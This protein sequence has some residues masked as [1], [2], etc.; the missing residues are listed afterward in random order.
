MQNRIIHK[1]AKG[2]NHSGAVVC[3]PGNKPVAEDPFLQF[4]RWFADAGKKGNK[5]PGAMHLSTCGKNGRPSG[6]MVLLKNVDSSG[7]VFF[8]N[9]ESRKGK[10]IAEN[11]FVA[12]TFFWPE[13]ERQV[14]IEG[15][16]T[17]VTAR[18]SDKYFFSR[19]LESRMSACISPQSKV[20]SDRET[21]EKKWQ[22]LMERSDSKGLKRPSGWGGYRVVPSRFE[23]WQGREHRLHDRYLFRKKRGG[24]IMEILAP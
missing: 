23:F 12:L 6:R 14:R 21:L 7:F 11:G 16:A 22:Q 9:Y 10:Q 19:P 13:T 5:E 3:G 2:K 20:I 8:T 17:K 18:E 1:K 15:K 4:T 24:W